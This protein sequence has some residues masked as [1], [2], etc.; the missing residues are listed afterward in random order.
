MIVGEAGEHGDL[1]VD[2]FGSVEFEGVG[3]DFEDGVGVAC[4]D[5]LGQF[6]LDHVGFRRGLAGLVA[7]PLAA[8]MEL[9]AIEQARPVSG[10]G[11][12]RVGEVG[13]GGFAVGAGDSDDGESASRVI[14]E[15][16]GDLR[17]D[18]AGVVDADKGDVWV[19]VGERLPELATV[20]LDDQGG[21]AVGDGGLEVL[22]AVDGESRDGDEGSA[23]GY[24]SRVLGDV[25]DTLISVRRSL[26]ATHPLQNLA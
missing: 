19:G 18:G 13:G 4:G 3:A 15:G 11:E 24:A 10:G 7:G 21:C 22:V 23:R 14:V 17:E 26:G 2:L 25:G 9:D 8:D 12:D 16:G 5:H 20:V 1:G 6:G